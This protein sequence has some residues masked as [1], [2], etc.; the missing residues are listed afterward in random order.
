[1][2]PERGAR[3]VRLQNEIPD[4]VRFQH[5]I[6]DRLDRSVTAPVTVSENPISNDLVN[7]R[8][9][10]AP[11]P[12]MTAITDRVNALWNAD[13]LSRRPVDDDCSTDEEPR[14]CKTVAS[15]TEAAREQSDTK[16]R[17]QAPAGE[18]LADLQR[19]DPDSHINKL[20][21]WETDNPPKSW[22]TDDF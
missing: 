2:S 16:P 18:S 8:P 10:S 22:V 17:V 19:Q 4:A 13:A 14:R 3:M 5:E 1:M 15:R 7:S 9:R 11:L 21:T 12:W 6:V 20:K